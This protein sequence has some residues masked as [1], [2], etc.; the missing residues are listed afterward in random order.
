MH[1]FRFKI[2]QTQD[3]QSQ[4]SE[5][6]NV[7]KRT[8][9]ESQKT[10]KQLLNREL[11]SVPNRDLLR[12]PQKVRH[13]YFKPRI[14][15]F[16]FFLLKPKPSVHSCAAHPFFTGW[17]DGLVRNKELIYIEL[18]KNSACTWSMRWDRFFCLFFFGSNRLFPPLSFEI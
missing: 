4:A 3:S 1:Y 15:F 18:T 10:H 16:F 11:G 6:S 12:K 13:W 5:R 7:K 17:K 9:L 2:Q 14:S 8:R